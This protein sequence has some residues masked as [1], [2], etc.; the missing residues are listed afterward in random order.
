VAGKVH[1]VGAGPGD[2]GLLTLRAAELLRRADVILHDGLA[3]RRVLVHARPDATIVEVGKTPG[4]THPGQDA[5]NERMIAEARSGREVVRLKGGDPFLFARGSEEAQALSEA[6]VDFD[7]VPGISSPVAAAAYAGIPLTHRHHSSSVLVLTGHGAADGAPPVDDLRRAAATTGTIVILMGMRHLAAL[8]AAL[9]EGGRAADE[10]VAIVR[11]ATRPEQQTI[12]TSLADA[13]RDATAAGLAAPAVVIVG[14]VVRLRDALSWFERLPLF[15]RRVLVPR[16]AEQAGALAALLR[17]AGA[18]PLE[19]PAIR[20]APPDDLGPV[21]A[22]LAAL[23][24]TDLVVFAS[25]NAVHWFFRHAAAAGLDARCLGRARLCAVGPATAAALAD[26]GLRADLVPT[27]YHAEAAARAI[28]DAGPVAGLR[29]LV[30]RAETASEALPVMLKGAGAIVDVVTVYRTL[31]P[32][33]E[34]KATLRDAAAR[35]H[36]VVLTSG[37]TAENLV[38][39]L[40]AEE[41]RALL[42]ERAVVSIGPVTTDAARAAGLPPTL[43]ADEATMQGLVRA[44]CRHFGGNTP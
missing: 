18:E 3:D 15:G 31:P 38:A 34:G 36:A 32:D 12:V 43:T 28:L 37:S 44:L 13:A 14:A 41:T 7:V 42:A 39:A 1:L 29:V 8:A 10:P 40:G 6:G 25:A 5:I 9:I 33:E 16:A 23:P 27:T 35:C 30:P 24:D 11:W 22:A 26:V 2:P 21:R 4:K 17:E 20:V 19:V